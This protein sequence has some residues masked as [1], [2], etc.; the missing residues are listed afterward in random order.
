M[1][2]Q[3]LPSAVKWA[4]QHSDPVK[5]SV[6]KGAGGPTGSKVS[7]E[8][9]QVHVGFIG[10]CLERTAVFM[11]GDGWWMTGLGRA[12]TC[13]VFAMR[14]PGRAREAKRVRW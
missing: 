13:T 12:S 5:Q 3:K 6:R 9:W 2:V 8:Q 1:P 10:V 4:S 14:F 11:G 7:E